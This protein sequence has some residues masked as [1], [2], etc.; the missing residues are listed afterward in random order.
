MIKKINI[1]APDPTDGTSFYR[2]W[3][4][5]N[6]VLKDIDLNILLACGI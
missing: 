4:V 5:F 2:A 3:G 6:D 1:T